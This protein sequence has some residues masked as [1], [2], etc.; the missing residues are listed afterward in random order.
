MKMLNC[1][2]PDIEPWSTPLVTNSHLEFIPTLSAQQF[3][4]FLIQIPVHLWPVLLSLSV[5]LLRETVLKALLKN[6]QH[7]QLSS[8]PSSQL[9]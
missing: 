3:S 8:Y 5:K 6:N 2:D 4:Q 1:I 7:P 9:S